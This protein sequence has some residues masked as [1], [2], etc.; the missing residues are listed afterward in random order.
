MAKLS[1][2]S[3]LGELMAS[4]AAMAILEEYWPGV[5][6]DTRL[7]MAAAMTLKACAAFP[8]AAKIKEKLAEIDAKLQALG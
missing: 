7:K 5:S 1:Q 8:Q 2:D 4:P 6:K 3:K